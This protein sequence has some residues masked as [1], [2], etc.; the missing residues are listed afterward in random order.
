M[1]VSLNLLNRDMKQMYDHLYGATINGVWHPGVLTQPYRANPDPPRTTASDQTVIDGVPQPKIVKVY[2]GRGGSKISIRAKTA[3][4][5]GTASLVM[6]YQQHIFWSMKTKFRYHNENVTVYLKAPVQVYTDGT[7]EISGI[8]TIN[9]NLRILELD[10]VWAAKD[11]F[12]H[13]VPISFPG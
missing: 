10:S 1:A 12:N 9:R 3:N 8:W 2:G 13:P 5:A 11:N 6:D 4:P 7:Y